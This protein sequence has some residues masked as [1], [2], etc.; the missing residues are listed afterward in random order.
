MYIEKLQ[1]FVSVYKQISHCPLHILN[2]Y[3]HL[4]EGKYDVVVVDCHHSLCLCGDKMKM[5]LPNFFI[6]FVGHPLLP[7]SNLG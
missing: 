1:R 5:S 4:M 3:C 6:F 7:G 2:Y